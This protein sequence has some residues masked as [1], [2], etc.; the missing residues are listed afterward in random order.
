MPGSDAQL[1]RSLDRFATWRS[2]APVSV[3]WFCAL[4]LVVMWLRGTSEAA[5]LEQLKLLQFWSLNAC[6]AA[7]AGIAVWT[8]G[9]RHVDALKRH[10]SRLAVVA[11]V[12]LGLVLLA[13]PRTNRIFYDEQIY[14]SVGQNLADLRLAQV[15]SDGSVDNGRLHCARGEYNKQPYAYP[16]LLAL[17]YLLF[18]V[19]TWI[20]FAL[21]AAVMTATACAVYLLVI[22]LFG[23]PT[24]AFIAGLLI[25][26]MPEQLMWSATAAVEPSASLAAIIATICAARYARLGGVRRLAGLV[27]TAAYAIQFRPESI[28]ILPVLAVIAAPRAAADLERPAAWWCAV[29]LLLLCAVPAAHLFAVRHA[30][31]GTNAARFSIGFIPANLRVNGWFYLWDERFPRVDTLLALAGL[32]GVTRWLERGSVAAYF[33]VFF[34][35]DLAF[36]AGS[37][38]YGADIRYSLM[39]F[40]P[41]AVLA[42]LGAA[43]LGRPLT[44]IGWPAALEGLAGCLVALQVFLYLPVVRPMPEEAWAARQDVRFAETAS[45]RLPSGAYVLTQNPGMFHLWGINAGQMALAVADPGFL[46][47]IAPRA[48]GGVYVHWNFWCGVEDPVQPEICRKALALGRTELVEELLARDQRFAFYRLET[49][50]MAPRHAGTGP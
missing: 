46:E 22:V 23:D 31:W 20:A 12:A 42:G 15:C 27:V 50:Q 13:P 3:A 33:L 43:R 25:A 1:I 10:G 37:Y 21:N 48:R 28:L 2:W 5:L 9:A 38:D 4:A 39:T 11:L 6:L 49:A 32:F 45:Q 34:L 14:Q 29:L 40:P 36:Y 26:T 35:V 24:A 18:G 44:T 47:R 19:H 30:G 16:H 7:A 8:A 17:A 41:I